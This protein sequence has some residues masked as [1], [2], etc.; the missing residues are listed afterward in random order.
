MAYEGLPVHRTE[1][2]AAI[3][4]SKA[5]GEDGVALEMLGALGIWRGVMW[6]PKLILLKRYM[7]PDIS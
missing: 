4:Q 5:I 2:E 7:T 1:I 3:R 6:L